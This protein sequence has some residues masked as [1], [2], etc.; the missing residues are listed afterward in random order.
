M[1]LQSILDFVI[2]YGAYIATPI[3][4]AGLLQAAKK[5]FK[6]FFLSVWG[7][8][9]AYFLPFILGLAAGFLLPT[10]TM[11]EGIMV[12]MALGAVSHLIYKFF[13]KTLAA[14]LKLVGD[15]ERKSLTDINE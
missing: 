11:K 7:M 3:V 2:N 10:D 1:E 9:L 12:G 15:I 8:R 14:K 4:I 5:G 6:K 13:T